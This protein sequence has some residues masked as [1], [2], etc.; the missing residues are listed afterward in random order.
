MFESTPEFST[1]S[2]LGC[3]SMSSYSGT[4]RL[5]PPRW[6]ALTLVAQFG[7]I[8]V[9]RATRTARYGAIEHFEVLAYE[10]T[11]MNR[12][13]VPDGQQPFNVRQMDFA[14]VSLGNKIPILAV[15]LYSTHTRSPLSLE[16]NEFVPS[17]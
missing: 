6:Y 10:R 8:T 5:S 9:V 4:R 3:I 11:A 7:G 13:T 15:A 2:A 14:D 1:V 17:N 16:T 12:C